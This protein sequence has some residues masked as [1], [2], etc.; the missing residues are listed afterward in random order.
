MDSPIPS[1]D[2][3]YGEATSGRNQQILTEGKSLLPGINKN[4][5][6]K[7]AARKVAA[8]EDKIAAGVQINSHSDDESARGDNQD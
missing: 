3:P 8:A 5:N 2:K 4:K 6:D 7:K 1:T